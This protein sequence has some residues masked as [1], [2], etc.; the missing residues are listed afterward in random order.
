MSK[1]KQQSLYD[2]F[3]MI[4]C[5]IITCILVDL[6]YQY[7][8]KIT[9]KKNVES[10]KLDFW[11]KKKNKKNKFSIPSISVVDIPNIYTQY[12]EQSRP[13]PEPPEPPPPP[14]EQS[15]TVSSESV[16]S[17]DA[18][19]LT[20]QPYEGFESSTDDKDIKKTGFALNVNIHGKQPDTDSYQYN[21]IG[22]YNDNSD[23]VLPKQITI[24]RLTPELCAKEC[25]SLNYSHFGVQDGFACFCG[26]SNYDRLGSTSG[27]DIQ[28]TG[29]ENACGGYWKNAVYGI[30]SSPG[31]YQ[32]AGTTKL[33][34]IELYDEN[35]D[36]VVSKDFSDKIVGPD[37]NYINNETFII[38]S[39]EIGTKTIV[40]AGIS[41]GKDDV[42]IDSAAITC[43][44]LPSYTSDESVEIDLDLYSN[45]ESECYL[46]PYEKSK[47]TNSYIKIKNET[48][49][50]K[51]TLRDL[52]F[53]QPF[54][55]DQ[56]C[57]SETP[58]SS[59]TVN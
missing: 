41:V 46:N 22:C 25:G 10:L 48:I 28:C 16:P 9:E 38:T 39:E 13:E 44:Y 23:R 17:T 5:V 14:T 59:S 27:C 4:I 30:T 2:I 55:L 26:D 11:K 31:S 42:I 32:N 57:L 36:V 8:K 43:Y 6:V 7:W 54:T 49:D 58:G 40:S 18:N 56:A 15:G 12:I 47:I 21:Y 52:T 51:S 33:T 34:K 37:N 1:S 19:E 3:T 35:G 45:N 50:A 24:D 53:S 20:K 29:S